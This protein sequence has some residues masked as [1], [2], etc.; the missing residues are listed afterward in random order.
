MKINAL[1]LIFFSFLKNLLHMMPHLLC[2]GITDDYLEDSIHSNEDS[3]SVD[4]P[5]LSVGKG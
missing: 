2:Y 3:E 5:C 1:C 4:I